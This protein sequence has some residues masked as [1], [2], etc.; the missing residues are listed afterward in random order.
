[1][2]ESTA[3][4]LDFLTPEEQSFLAQ[5]PTIPIGVDFQ[6][7]PFEFQENG[8]QQGYSMDV[9]RLLEE[10]LGVRFT[11]VSKA[12]WSQTFALFEKGEIP[13][14]SMV[15]PTKEREAFAL[16]G[17]PILQANLALA[18]PKNAQQVVSFE[19]LVGKKVGAIAEYWYIPYIQQEHPRITLVTFSSIQEAFKGLLEGEI[20]AYLDIQPVLH[21]YLN[22]YFSTEFKASLPLKIPHAP[23][24]DYHIGVHKEFPLLRT[25]LD[26]TLHTIPP[27]TLLSLQQKWLGDTLAPS[28]SRQLLI[29]PQVQ[30]F[31][32][33]L[34]TLK[35]GIDT[36][37]P[38]F[39]FLDEQGH[40]KGVV[41]EVV[42]YI[43][44]QS[45]GITPLLVSAPVWKE[46]IE[47]IQTQKIDVI[48]GIVNNEERAKKMLFT[49]P[50]LTMPLMIL[51][52]FDEKL[53]DS[54]DELRGKNVGVVNG[55][56][57]GDILTQKYPQVIPRFFPDLKSGL[58]ALSQGEVD[59]FFDGLAAMNYTIRA[60]GITNLKLLGQTGE[61]YALS[62]GVRKDWPELVEALN[63]VIDTTPKE[64]IN[65]LID[66]WV[67]ME[68]QGSIDYSLAWKAVL[69]FSFI[70]AF[71]VYWNRRLHAEILHRKKIEEQLFQAQL[72]AEKAN[73]AKSEFL[74]NMSHEIRT[75]MNAVIGFADLT[76]KMDLPPKALHNIQTIQKS[77]K[78]L[79]GLINDI[80]D[81][82]KIEAGKVE[83]KREIVNV[84]SLAEDLQ[85]IFSLRAKHKTIYFETIVHQNTPKA[86]IFDE[87]RVRQILVNLI[88]NA[89]KFTHEGGVKVCFSATP[90]PQRDST[91][92]LHVKVEDTGIG[93][94]EEEQEKIF[95]MFEQQSGLNGRTYGG[96]GLGLAI[97]KKF[98]ELMG[99]VIRVK[100]APKKGSTFT[101]TLTHVEVAASLPS[102][103]KQTHSLHFHE[104]CVLVVDDIEENL[105]L[106]GDILETYGLSTILSA[107]GEE[108]IHLAEEERPNL[109]LM[110]I[111][112]PQVDGCTAAKAIRANAITAH[113]PI[114]AVS[115]SVLG[116]EDEAKNGTF[117]GF[118][119]KPIDIAE[120]ETLLMDF[121]PHEKKALP[122]APLTAQNNTLLAVS[123]AALP[124]LLAKA[125]EA[126][127]SGDFD[128][129]E[130][131]ILLLKETPGN[132]ALIE[133][134]ELGLEDIDIDALETKLTAIVAFLEK[135]VQDGI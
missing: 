91:V 23:L 130:E 108:A 135:R 11:L 100:S 114:I 35:L 133:N 54:L 27:Q 48:S 55:Y 53:I 87:L 12:Q 84:T 105:E 60:E 59:Y 49:N 116:E 117:D 16:F 24:V 118:I 67:H 8:I 28:L 1:M 111:K 122:C 36:S 99:G 74:S 102:R 52:R 40:H 110:D 43:L 103:S 125:K 14:L 46:H 112:M 26:K 61:V 56:V 134:L 128:I 39:E 95:G 119:P 75:P 63:Y 69:I 73:Q 85:A 126:L 13:A 45:L 32:S 4:S 94:L 124:P 113:I 107:S 34:H 121:L 127:N 93:I 109:I 15:A 47:A 58:I 42:D 2:R 30:Q 70:I 7:P 6:W 83:I 66:P 82:S 123:T 98:A 90:N 132:E 131:L 33:N 5:N 129:I 57:T 44:T 3:F 10:R 64:T 25:I 86:L 77:A 104:A 17:T 22:R 29:R 38:P 96:T 18:L 19:Q 106:L 76:A 50:Y 9:L 78:A 81:L 92:D 120:L 97:S 88:G 79:V 31:L 51:G 41:Q 62:F 80:L 20:D 21:Y 101:L 89:V 72:R 37:W 71:I 65:R 115:A 68:I